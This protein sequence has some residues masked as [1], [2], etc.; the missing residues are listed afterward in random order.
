[1]GYS[2]PWGRDFFLVVMRCAGTRQWLV[3]TVAQP[4]VHFTMPNFMVCKGYFL[5]KEKSTVQGKVKKE[6]P[7]VPQTPLTHVIGGYV[8]LWDSVAPPASFSLIAPLWGTLVPWNS[9]QS[10][11]ACGSMCRWVCYFVHIRIGC[12]RA[13][14]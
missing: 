10:V 13:S 3:V 7:L 9:E 12:I 1:M 2:C 5:V 4:S 14:M 6:K 8:P 11:L